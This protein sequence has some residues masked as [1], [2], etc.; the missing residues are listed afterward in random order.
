MREG[1]TLCP[2]LF[3][4]VWHLVSGYL[5]YYFKTFLPHTRATEWL[6]LL[7]AALNA[8]RIRNNDYT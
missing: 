5:G 6:A 4:I 2:I 1:G 3:F 7:R 8:E